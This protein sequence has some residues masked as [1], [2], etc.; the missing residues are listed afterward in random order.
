M[1]L[2]VA[3]GAVS[4]QMRTTPYS[5]VESRCGIRKNTKGK[6]PTEELTKRKDEAIVPRTIE[7]SRC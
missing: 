4:N 7:L 2:E 1:D 5:Q 6:P 3:Q